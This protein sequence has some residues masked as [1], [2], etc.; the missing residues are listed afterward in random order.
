MH[1]SS[2]VPVMQG[3]E[4]IRGLETSEETVAA[5]QEVAKKMGKEVYVSKDFP[6]FIGNRLFPLFVNEAF[7]VLME[8]IGTAEDI[9][10]GIRLNLRHP[11]GPLELADFV[12][13]DTILSILDYLHGEI[14][15]RYRPCP[16]LR[17][18]VVGGCLGVKTKK[19]VYD[20]T[21]GTKKTRLL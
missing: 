3:L 21:S 4:M 6:G 13:L 12:G 15:E 16:L 11:M 5:M 18:L 1:F 2:P 7:Y 9:D 14:G 8:G 19:G 17:K 10:K 20:Y